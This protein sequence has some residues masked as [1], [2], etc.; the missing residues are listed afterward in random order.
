MLLRERVIRTV[1]GLRISRVDLVLNLSRRGELLRE[2][3]TEEASILLHN[4]FVSTVDNLRGVCEIL[5]LPLLVPEEIQLYRVRPLPYG[6]LCLL[7]AQ[8]VESQFRECWQ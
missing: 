7:V 5:L 1:D 2:F 6:L 4:R 3:L 8:G